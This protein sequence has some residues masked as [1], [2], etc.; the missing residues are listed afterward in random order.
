VIVVAATALFGWL[1]TQAAVPRLPMDPR[2]IAVLGVLL[3]LLAA[4]VGR[5]LWKETRFS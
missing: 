1:A 3:V 5:R 2:W 4:F